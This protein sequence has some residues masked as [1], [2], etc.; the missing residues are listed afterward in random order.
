MDCLLCGFLRPTIQTRAQPILTSKILLS[1]TKYVTRIVRSSLICVTWKR[2][3]PTTPSDTIPLGQYNRPTAERSHCSFERT[4][5]GR[6]LLQLNRAVLAVT[7]WPVSIVVIICFRRR[8]RKRLF[9]ACG[10]ICNC[11]DASIIIIINVDFKLRNFPSTGG[12]SASNA[13]S[14][15]SMLVYSTGG[16]LW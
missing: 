14:R 2:P 12:A 13:I 15:D 10:V 7:T 3:L 8:K 11:I 1:C 4:D 9:Y 16:L 5:R 6:R